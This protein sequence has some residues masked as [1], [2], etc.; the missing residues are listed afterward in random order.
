MQLLPLFIVSVALEL[1]TRMLGGGNFP[2]WELAFSPLLTAALWPLATA[3]LLAP[4]RRAH[5]PDENR[6]L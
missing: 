6:P 4:Q 3:L 2:G 5:D 1:L